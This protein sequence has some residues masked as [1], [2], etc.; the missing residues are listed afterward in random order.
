V[1]RLRLDDAARAE[2]LHE[3]RYLEDARTG[4]GKRFRQAVAAVFA[5]VRAH[6]L[7]PARGA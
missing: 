2:L 6:P 4:L 1:K 5:R 3:V 7:R